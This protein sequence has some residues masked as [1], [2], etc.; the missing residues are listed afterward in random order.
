[1]H[2]EGTDGTGAA[3][4]QPTNITPRPAGFLRA[5]ILKSIFCH[6]FLPLYLKLASAHPMYTLFK[7]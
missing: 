3:L 6:L 5:K 7:I 2:C 1:M 4:N